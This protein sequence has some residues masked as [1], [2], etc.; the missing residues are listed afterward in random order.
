MNIHLSSFDVFRCLLGAISF[1][2]TK[3]LGHAL[4]SPA[5]TSTLLG[6]KMLAGWKMLAAACPDPAC[7]GTPLMQLKGKPKLCV[8]CSAEYDAHGHKVGSGNVSGI[9][10][11]AVRHLLTHYTSFCLSLLSSD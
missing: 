7:R 6:N 8:C 4:Q 10:S 3:P 11:G 5:E 9:S 1:V 2:F